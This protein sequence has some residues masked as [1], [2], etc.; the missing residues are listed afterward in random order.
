VET[1]FQKIQRLKELERKNKFV[2][3]S[4]FLKE[5]TKPRNKKHQKIYERI[6]NSQNKG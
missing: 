3:Q 5:N 2:F 1:N 6:N 4:K